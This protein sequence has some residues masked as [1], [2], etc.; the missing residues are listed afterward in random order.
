[1]FQATMYDAKGV[2]EDLDITHD[3]RVQQRAQFVLWVA[4]KLAGAVIHEQRRRLC[5]WDDHEVS[6]DSR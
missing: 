3:Q 1:M 5:F 2:V 4:E 6:G